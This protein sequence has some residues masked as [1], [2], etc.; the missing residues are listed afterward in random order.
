MKAPAITFQIWHGPLKH[1]VSDHNALQVFKR[2]TARV[3]SGEINP[4]EGAWRLVA[5]THISQK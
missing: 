5:I 4:T 3:R 2:L 1:T